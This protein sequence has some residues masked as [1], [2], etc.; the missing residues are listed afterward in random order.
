MQAP[1]YPNTKILVPVF[2]ERRGSTEAT[3]ASFPSNSEARTE[4]LGPTTS[5]GPGNEEQGEIT[6]ITMR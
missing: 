1:L 5:N 6:A 3:M 2:M 4:A